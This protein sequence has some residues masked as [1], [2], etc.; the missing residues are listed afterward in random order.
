MSWADLQM[1]IDQLR[2]PGIIA[3]HDAC[4][5]LAMLQEHNKNLI[6]LMETAEKNGLVFNSK[7]CSIRQPEITF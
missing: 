7:K 6:N 1:W 5:S 4:A 3:L 2:L